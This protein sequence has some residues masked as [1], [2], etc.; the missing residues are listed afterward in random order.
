MA[1]GSRRC[2]PSRRT[3]GSGASRRARSRASDGNLYGTTYEGGAHSSGTIFTID[4]TTLELTTLHELRPFRRRLF[5][6]R[7]DSGRRTETSTARRPGRRPWRRH[8]LSDRHRRRAADDPPRASM[9]SDG[10][11]PAGA[12]GPGR[13]RQALRNRH[14]GAAPAA[15]ERSSRSTPR[16]RRLRDAPQLRCSRTARR[17]RR[18]S[19]W[20]PTGNSTGRQKS[21]A[22]SSRGTVFRLDTDGNSFVAVHA[23]SG[24]DG[25]FPWAALLEAERRQALRHDRRH[26]EPAP[27][28][29]GRSSGSSPTDPCSRR[30]RLSALRRQGSLR[31]ASR[32]RRSGTPGTVYGTT[33][34]GG[35][36][37]FG[38]HLRR[39][40]R[41]FDVR[42]AS[43]ASPTSDGSATLCALARGR[44]WNPVGTTFSGGGSGH[45][46][47]FK[48]D[49][50]GHDADDAARLHGHGRRRRE[51]GKRRHPRG[52]DG[53]LY[54][55][56]ESGGA[57]ANFG[58]VFR[59]GTDGNDYATV[60]SFDGSDGQMPTGAPHR[61]RRTGASTARPTWAAPTAVGT[62]YR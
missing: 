5:D 19:S 40:E 21:R 16:A 6:R 23:F 57:N 14:S 50:T 62:I 3:E 1:R 8:D 49:P 12:L 48:L 15:R 56:T 13:Q 22:R 25:G 27:A 33:S 2:T 58:A 4:I 43:R 44:R 28:S 52:R 46:T 34:E 26:G 38:D 47:V 41:R 61:R 42:R 7:P 36:R 24:Q 60:H 59:I 54:G 11:H 9:T 51:P 17:P 32:S 29:T 18:A 20:E 53:F 35:A 39:R 55:T 30:C 10:A 31:G 45:G 37:G